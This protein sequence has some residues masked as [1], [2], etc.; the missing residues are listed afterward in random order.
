[1]DTEAIVQAYQDGTP[2]TQIID[3]FQISTLTLYNMLA[4]HGVPKRNN[5]TKAKSSQLSP[6]KFEQAKRDYLDAYDS[7]DTI[8]SRYQTTAYL[9]RQQLA[10]AGIQIR[11]KGGPGCTVTVEQVQELLEQ[12][13]SHE[14]A[15]ETLGCSVSQTY[16]LVPATSHN[17]R[18][19]RREQIIQAYHAW[20]YSNIVSLAQMCDCSTDLVD[21]TLKDANLPK[22]A[23]TFRRYDIVDLV[24]QK[25]AAGATSGELAKEFKL[26]QS[27]IASMIRASPE[28]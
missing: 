5:H 27:T 19:L 10:E 15:A 21:A 12:G 14:D 28:V 6:E 18:A 11:P 8:A 13:M 16:R 26:A 1:M 7:I 2:V 20:P 23:V 24:K 22:H 9:L 3:Q 17:T 4:E 25:A